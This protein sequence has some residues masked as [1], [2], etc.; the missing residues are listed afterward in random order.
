M[1]IKPLLRF[2]ASLVRT[3]AAKL[4]AGFLREGK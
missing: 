2:S 4:L 1:P 3:T